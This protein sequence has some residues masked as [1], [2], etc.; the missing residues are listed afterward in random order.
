LRWPEKYA[1]QGAHVF[2]TI[3]DLVGVLEREGLIPAPEP[4]PRLSAV[5]VG[6]A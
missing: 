6:A 2:A 4:A 5:N 1:A 3:E